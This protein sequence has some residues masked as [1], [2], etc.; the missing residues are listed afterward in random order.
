M[1][2]KSSCNLVSICTHLFVRQV[3][4]KLL[5]TYGFYILKMSGHFYCSV[6]LKPQSLLVLKL[7]PVF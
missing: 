2:M 3:P 5:N 7:H 4:S 6:T 1:P